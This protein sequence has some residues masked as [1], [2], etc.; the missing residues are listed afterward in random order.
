MKKSL[1]LIIITT[2][3]M[4]INVLCIF[5]MVDIETVEWGF[6]IS[7]IYTLFYNLCGSRGMYKMYRE[8]APERKKSAPKKTIY[9]LIFF[10]SIGGNLLTFLVALMV[11]YN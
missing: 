8:W 5:N 7:V 9:E 4:V 11:Y 6:R 3:A 2:I 1:I 10:C